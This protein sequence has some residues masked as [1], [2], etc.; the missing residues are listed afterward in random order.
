MKAWA[1]GFVWR[2]RIKKLRKQKAEE[3]ARRAAMEEA[4]AKAAAEEAARSAE[5]EEAAARAAA[6][7]AARAAEAE[8]A[9]RW[10]R[11]RRR[12]LRATS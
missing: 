4:A 8:A 3:E 11:R 10:P 7:E 6:A 2:Q 12:P 5:R 1:R 9:L